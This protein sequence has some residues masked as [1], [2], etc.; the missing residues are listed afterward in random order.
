MQFEIIRPAT[1]ETEVVQCEHL[2]EAM[3]MAGLVGVDFGTVHRGL[4]IVVYEFSLFVPAAE[5]HYFVLGGRL[6]GGNA[7]LYSYDEAGETVD[8]KTAVIPFWMDNVAHVERAIADG[9]CVRPQM[10]VN[11]NVIWQWPNPVPEDIIAG[12]MS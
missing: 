12:R 6:Y 11:R 9:A 1:R 2:N 7:V 10:A 4:G 5:Q 3:V 8:L